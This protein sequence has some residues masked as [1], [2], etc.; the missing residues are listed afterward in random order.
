[1]KK[2]KLLAPLIV[3]ASG[4]LLTAPLLLYGAPA[5]GDMIF[6]AMWQTNFSSQLSAG[7]LYPRWLLDMNGGLGS[8]V[9]FFYAPLPYYITALLTPF[10]PGGSYGLA[11]LGASLS[12]AVVASG[13]TAYLWLK[14]TTGRASA[15]AAAVIYML[16][17]YHLGVD[18]YTRGAFAEVWAFVWM[19]L[20]LYFVRRLFT[21]GAGF[22]FAL[23]G[24]ALSYAALIATHL[25][26]TLIFSLVPPCYALF[27][28]APRQ[29]LRSLIFTVGGMSLGIGL[30]CVYLLPALTT[31]EYVSLGDL[32]PELYHQ[33]WPRLSNLNHA[34]LD[35]RITLAVLTTAAM[36]ACAA[37]L[38]CRN[39]NVDAAGDDG[40]RPGKREY[41]FWI[42]VSLG[43]LLLMTPMSG[44]VWR[45][46]KPLQSIQ[47]PWR[48]NAVL[49]VAAAAI[50]ADG[51]R[52]LRR[53]K[54]VGA[55]RLAAL[56]VAC[57]LVIGWV[58]FT[59]HVARKEFPS[60][61]RGS[62]AGTD[63]AYL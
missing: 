59:V 58:V 56:V 44:F 25:P 20:V 63:A 16:A 60:L 15:A 13:L 18:V 9:F 31:Q 30:A 26:T 42:V 45:L 38:A 7:D 28:C 36:I 29:R 10:L 22:P 23:P 48:F 3:C 14:V 50:I 21:A 32:L 1:M 54:P 4:L 27:V 35:G 49:C 46:V 41:M 40:Q 61:R 19:P 55:F 6:H 39:D 62:P 24:L 51:V 34:E 37:V 8:P 5:V 43:C 17:P 11:H 57:V 47:F 12:L 52:A 2:R 33:R 53:A